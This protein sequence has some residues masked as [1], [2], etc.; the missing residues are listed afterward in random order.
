M[1]AQERMLPRIEDI[2]AS[3]ERVYRLA[4]RTPMLESHALSERLRVAVLLKAEILQRTGSFK[5][6]GAANHIALLAERGK[7]AGVVAASAGNHAQGVALAAA[8]FG[9]PCTI[10]MPR[11]ASIAKVEAT[12]RLGAEI[13]LQGASFAECAALAGTLAEE[14]G[15]NFVPAYDDPEVI[16]GQGTVGLEILV[17]A[18]DVE[19]VLIPVGGG[20]LA[21]GVALAVK[22]ARPSTRVVGVQVE[23][24]PGAFESYRSGSIET[25][26][27]ATT[28]A[29]GIAV[30]APGRYTLPLLRACLDDMVL[31][32]EEAVASAMLF[33]LERNKLMVEGA[34]SVGVAALLSGA[35][36]ARDRTVAVLSGGNID[37]NLVQQVIEHGLSQAGRFQS[38]M[39][40]IPDRP[41][42]LAAVLQ[43]IA[44]KGGNVLT[45]EHRRTGPNLP[46]DA[47]EV[48]LMV[49]TRNREHADE[50]NAALRESGFRPDGAPDSR[51]RLRSV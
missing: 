38:Y 7:P 29:D 24:A 16:A 13:V 41:G 18:P 11:E 32:D 1:M 10:V 40:L 30:A 6:R 20:G 28:L 8:T 19:Q 47:V 46:F 14:R 27:S 22:S 36:T 43:T 42:Q 45:I 15:L 4:R 12:R 44:G 50:I 5:V 26:P 37:V 39:L 2:R 3:A 49:E 48:E 17:E 33:L 21:A 31:V 23:A 51:S 35:V 9:I 25:H 34:G